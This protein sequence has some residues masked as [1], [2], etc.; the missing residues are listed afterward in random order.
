M[1]SVGRLHHVEINR[2]EFGLNRQT[3][4][5][6]FGGAYSATA[7]ARSENPRARSTR[8]SLASQGVCLLD[9]RKRPVAALGKPLGDCGE[10]DRRA[11]HA[12]HL[13]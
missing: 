3:T 10:G 11:G 7:A 4:T 9:A 6:V 5:V 13:G 8:S 2:Y 12:A 1:F